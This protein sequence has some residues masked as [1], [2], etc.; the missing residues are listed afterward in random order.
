[1]AYRAVNPLSPLVACTGDLL[2]QKQQRV[3]RCA[4]NRGIGHEMIT[5]PGMST[6]PDGLP[7]ERG[8]RKDSTQDYNA[9]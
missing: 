2:M 8:P 5:E 3:T 6:H 7:S 1:M 9:S 4:P